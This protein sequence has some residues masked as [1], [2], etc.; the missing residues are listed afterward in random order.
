M[1]AEGVRLRVSIDFILACIEQG[2]DD[3]DLASVEIPDSVPN[4]IKRRWKQALE[5]NNRADWKQ[6]AHLCSLSACELF[7]YHGYDQ[8]NPE[9]KFLCALARVSHL[10]SILCSSRPILLPTKER[11]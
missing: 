2:F 4:L 10:R 1:N 7:C 5:V 11:V 3:T 6:M 8:G 9:Y